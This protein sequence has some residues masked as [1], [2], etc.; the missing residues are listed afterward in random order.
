[1]TNKKLSVVFN[2][3]SNVL[4]IKEKNNIVLSVKTNEVSNRDRAIQRFI[5]DYIG[6]DCLYIEANSQECL[7]VFKAI[8]S[9][10]LEKAELSVIENVVGYSF[11]YESVDVKVKQYFKEK[12]T[13]LCEQNAK[14]FI[15]DS[16]DNSFDSEIERKRNDTQRKNYKKKFNEYAVELCKIVDGTTSERKI[17][18]Y[19]GFS[20]GKSSLLNSIL[21]ETIFPEKQ[22]ESTPFVC[23]IRDCKNKKDS[24]I[25]VSFFDSGS[26]IVHEFPANKKQMTRLYKPNKDIVSVELYYPFSNL[27]THPG[28]IIYDT[29]GVMGMLSG[30]HKE[31]VLR[32]VIEYDGIVLFII[33][34]S[35]E[36]CFERTKKAFSNAVE[37]FKKEGYSVEKMLEKIIPV[38]TKSDLITRETYCLYKEKEIFEKIRILDFEK[39]LIFISN[40]EKP[41]SSVKD[42]ILNVVCSGDNG[43]LNLCNSIQNKPRSGYQDSL[44]AEIKKNINNFC[45]THKIFFS[46]RVLDNK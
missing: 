41:D 30:Y 13:L 5:T 29:P 1:M 34:I 17:I 37:A 27:N 25:M 23:S 2:R 9:Q 33:D 38:V 24:K 32:D 46:M 45:S 28:H 43:I 16:R 26:E 44:V 40:S 4:Q 18:V 10:L 20:S 14:K 6:Y 3:I 11:D 7:D 8:F 42:S 36:D 22:E 19:G 31:N 12:I 21:G 35:N 15:E 39:N